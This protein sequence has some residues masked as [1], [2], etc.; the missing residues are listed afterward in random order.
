MVRGGRLELGGG[1]ERRFAALQHVGEVRRVWR[2]LE[3]GDWGLGG[4]SLGSAERLLE[5]GSYLRCIDLVYHSTLGLRVIK[6]KKKLGG[7]RLGCAPRRVRSLECRVARAFSGGTCGVSTA[8]LQTLVNSTP[9]TLFANKYL[10]GGPRQS[11]DSGR[12]R[13]RVWGLG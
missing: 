3:F 2:C 5:A 1:Q 7:S 10:Y 12:A 9:Y 13:S 6:K 4:A 11:R 8:L